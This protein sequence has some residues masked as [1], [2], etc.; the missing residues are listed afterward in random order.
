[1]PLSPLEYLR[2]ILDETGFLMAR[3]TGLTKD[4]FVSDEALRR[5]FAR[6]L[7]IIGEAAKRVPP[8]WR[9]RYPAVD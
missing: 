4:E 8:E 2:H 6:S 3:S 7:E 5:A 1:M 9:Q